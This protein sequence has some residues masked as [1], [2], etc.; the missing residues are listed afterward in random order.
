MTLWLFVLRPYVDVLI[1][2]IRSCMPKS[3]VSAHDVSD[4]ISFPDA[5]AAG[6]IVVRARACA[7]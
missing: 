4:D 2:L 1:K 3:A 6:K 5:L 7:R